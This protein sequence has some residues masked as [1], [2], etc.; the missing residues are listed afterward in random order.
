MSHPPPLY[1]TPCFHITNSREPKYEVFVLLLHSL[2]LYEISRGFVPQIRGRKHGVLMLVAGN[3]AN[4]S[5]RYIQGGNLIGVRPSLLL[6]Y[7]HCIMW[8]N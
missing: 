7:E 3:R 2:L 5:R 1:S 6:T 4:Q 8:G